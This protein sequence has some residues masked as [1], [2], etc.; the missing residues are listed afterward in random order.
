MSS[1]EIQYLFTQYGLLL[2]GVCLL[3]ATVYFYRQLVKN[4]NERNRR[5]LETDIKRWCKTVLMTGK[6]SPGALQRA[7]SNARERYPQRINLILEAY[8]DL[9]TERPELG[10]PA[11][12]KFLES[13]DGNEPGKWP[14]WGDAMSGKLQKTFGEKQ[15]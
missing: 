12:Y 4:D 2:S 6:D 14:S 1:F 5:A 9:L 11:L 7:G 8:E 3:I 15:R 10:L 13:M